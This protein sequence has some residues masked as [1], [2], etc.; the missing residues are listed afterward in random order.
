M[1]LLMSSR[2]YGKILESLTNQII[3]QYFISKREKSQTLV[4]LINIRNFLLMKEYRV[5]KGHIHSELL[6]IGF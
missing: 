5:I 1:N 2:L 3:I 4:K 6:S